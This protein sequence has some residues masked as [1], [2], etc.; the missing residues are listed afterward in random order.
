MNVSEVFAEKHWLLW[1]ACECGGTY[2]A[3]T[4]D[5]SKSNKGLFREIPLFQEL[6]ELLDLRGDV[7]FFGNDFAPNLRSFH[8]NPTAIRYSLRFNT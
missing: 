8:N 2:R 3:C 4:K 6:L 1:C 7:G 5:N